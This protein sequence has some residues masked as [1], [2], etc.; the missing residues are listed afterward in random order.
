LLIND[1]KKQFK[2]I[3]TDL[4]AGVTVK[5]TDSAIFHA[6]VSSGF[7]TNQVR[8][9]LVVNQTGIVMFEELAI[10]ANQVTNAAQSNVGN[11]PTP[12]YG[13]AAVVGDQIGNAKLTRSDFGIELYPNATV[14]TG[15]AAKFKRDNKDTVFVTFETTDNPELVLNFYRAQFA[16]VSNNRPITDQRINGDQVFLGLL[17]GT[18]QES[19]S[20]IVSKA[21]MT[22]EVTVMATKYPGAR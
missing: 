6:N 3:P 17:N 15:T 22:T 7:S 20:V 11:V 5:P 13:T 9:V 4:R 18:E 1:Q 10:G 19:L 16:S 12:N 2:F 8:A 21:L 14:K